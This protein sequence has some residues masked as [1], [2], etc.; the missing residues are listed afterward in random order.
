MKP[1]THISSLVV[2]FVILIK[3]KETVKYVPKLSR[4][5]YFIE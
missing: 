5:L 4:L 1:E 3:N 2:I